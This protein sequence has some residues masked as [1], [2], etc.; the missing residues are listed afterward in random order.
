MTGDWLM[1]NAENISHWRQGQTTPRWQ[2]GG[3]C[4]GAPLDAL[5]PSMLQLSGTLVLLLGMEQ[6]R[7]AESLAS[8]QKHTCIQ[9]GSITTPHRLSPGTSPRTR[10][11]GPTIWTQRIRAKLWPPLTRKQNQVSGLY[12]TPTRQYRINNYRERKLIPQ[13]RLKSRTNSE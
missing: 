2:L 4:L 8:D 11:N 12:E 6:G 9:S 10:D 5:S 3:V 7:T 13:K 1:Q